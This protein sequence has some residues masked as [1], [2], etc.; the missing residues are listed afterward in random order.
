MD[1]YGRIHRQLSWARFV[2]GMPTLL[3]ENPPQ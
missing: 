3:G 1:Q 2:N